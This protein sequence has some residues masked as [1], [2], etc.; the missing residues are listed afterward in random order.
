MSLANLRPQPF[1]LT[2]PSEIRR[3]LLECEGYLHTCRRDHHG[4]DFEGR[5]YAMEALKALADSYPHLQQNSEA[6]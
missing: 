2:N 3:L 5:R 4:T 1:D 6:K